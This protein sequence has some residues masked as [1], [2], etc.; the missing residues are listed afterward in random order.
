[1]RNLLVGSSARFPGPLQ[2]T[3]RPGSGEA[4]GPGDGLLRDRPVAK[5]LPA[6]H[7]SRKVFTQAS[8]DQPPA[9]SSL[10]VG[11]ECDGPDLA[12]VVPGRHQFPTGPGV[13]EAH[14]LVLARR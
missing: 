12:A 4:S 10:A 5:S 1:M 13:P 3:A 7:S 2:H 14:R 6:L 9:A 11:T 8:L